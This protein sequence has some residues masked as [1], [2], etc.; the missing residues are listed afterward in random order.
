VSRTFALYEVVSSRKAGR[1]FDLYSDTRSQSYDGAGRETE[2]T[3]AAVD[4]T[5]GEVVRY[6][7]RVIQ[8]FFHSASGGMTES[9]ME[10]FGNYRPYLTP[11]QSPYS[12][13]YRDDR[14]ETTMQLGRAAAIL[15]LTNGISAVAVTARTESKRIKTVEFSDP[16]GNKITLQGKDLREM[17]GANSMKSTRANIRI[18]GDSLVISGAGYGHGVGMGQWDALG[19]AR[20]GYDYKFILTYFYKGTSVDRIW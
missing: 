19:M 11:V 15:R 18:S 2:S 3:S 1:V 12:S 20:Q 9:S 6:G 8:A 5:I 14:W 17:F 7:G 16:S 4:A 13:V 10:V